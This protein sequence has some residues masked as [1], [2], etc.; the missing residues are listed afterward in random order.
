MIVESI[1]FYGIRIISIL[2]IFTNDERESIPTYVP[3]TFVIW[4]R[5][6][7]QIGCGIREA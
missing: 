1:S 2:L 7:S 6:Y 5:I 4:A 3:T